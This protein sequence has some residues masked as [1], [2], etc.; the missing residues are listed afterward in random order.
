MENSKVVISFRAVFS[1]HLTE[2]DFEIID[3]FINTGYPE[4]KRHAEVGGFWYG[5]ASRIVWA[6][7]KKREIEPEEFTFRELDLLT[8][9]LE[10]SQFRP[11]SRDHAQ[12]LSDMFFNALKSA[13]EQTG[14]A[15]EAYS[16]TIEL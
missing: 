2:E 8:K 3:E 16:K 11:K 5:V 10:P 4:M 14:K 13:N 15:I 1:F 6:V 7:E 12:K 9:A